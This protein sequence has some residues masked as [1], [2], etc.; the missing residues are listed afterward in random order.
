MIR[1]SSGFIRGLIN[2]FVFQ[3]TIATVVLLFWRSQS[4]HACEAVSWSSVMMRR[5]YEVCWTRRVFTFCNP[6]VFHQS[7]FKEETS[8]RTECVCVY[9]WCDIK[10]IQTPHWPAPSCIFHY[11]NMHWW[12]VC[13]CFN[14]LCCPAI[15]KDCL[16]SRQTPVCS[17]TGVRQIPAAAVWP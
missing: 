6:S 8:W 13:A 9:V 14:D 7:G 17:P 3:V 5:W 1:L 10:Q 4:T 12:G 11:V 15:I 16:C 2:V